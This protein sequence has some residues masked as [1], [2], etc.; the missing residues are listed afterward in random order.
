MNEAFGD[1][2]F[3]LFNAFLRRRGTKTSLWGDRNSKR[4][5]PICFE[6]STVSDE[7][8]TGH[9][10]QL[11]VNDQLDSNSSPGIV[12]LTKGSCGCAY[13]AD[14]QQQ[15]PVKTGEDEER[16]VWWVRRQIIQ[17]DQSSDWWDV[18]YLAGE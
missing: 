5:L 4:D 13:A 2:L 11:R 17:P 6:K 1:V 14:G 8:D 3:P 10:I 18:I 16:K 15:S 12:P 7:Q 9:S